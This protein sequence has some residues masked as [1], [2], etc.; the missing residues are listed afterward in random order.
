MRAGKHGSQPEDLQTSKTGEELWSF[1]QIQNQETEEFFDRFGLQ[2]T[3]ENQRKVLTN[4]FS[5]CIDIFQKVVLGSENL[6][7][8]W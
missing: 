6:E 4:F 8:E 2:N 1:L 3:H 7:P 5:H